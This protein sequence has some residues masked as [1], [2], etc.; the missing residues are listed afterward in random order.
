M[1]L[2]RNFFFFQVKK[3]LFAGSLTAG[4][5][6]GLTAILDEWE[7]NHSQQDDRWLA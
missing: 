2:N 6:S 1:S 3:S 7:T 5:L 4:Q